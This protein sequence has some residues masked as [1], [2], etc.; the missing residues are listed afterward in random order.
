MAAIA[1]AAGTTKA[2]LYARFPSKEAV[3]ERAFEWAMGRSDWPVPEPELPDSDSLE[4]TLTAIAEAAVR[5]ALDPQMVAVFKIAI[6]QEARFPALGRRARLVHWPRQRQV[7]DLLRRHAAAGAIVADEP[8]IL[9]GHFLA[10]VAT[11]PSLFAAFGVTRDPAT[12]KVERQ[13][14]VE[15]FVRALRP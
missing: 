5:R 12:Q 14:A 4:E 11:A 6:A 7:A 15:L 9:A 1:Q 2:T 8:E 13:V 10:M 3:F